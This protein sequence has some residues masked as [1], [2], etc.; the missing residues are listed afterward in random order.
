MISFLSYRQR[1]EIYSMN[2]NSRNIVS[3]WRRR[4]PLVDNGE[5]NLN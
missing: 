1:M 5:V 4:L 2:S 3:R